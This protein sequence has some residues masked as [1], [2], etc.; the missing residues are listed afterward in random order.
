MRC[1][2][3]GVHDRRGED[4]RNAGQ[5]GYGTGEMQDMYRMRDRWDAQQVRCRTSGMQDGWNTG[6]EGCRTGGLRTGGIQGR[7]DAAQVGSR[8]GG[9]Q[10]GRIQD[11]WDA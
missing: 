7:R 8:R 3:G 4:R 1:R 9:M 11:R 10:D 6:Q 2:T 5:V